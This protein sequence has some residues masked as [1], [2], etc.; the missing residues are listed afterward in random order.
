MSQDTKAFF[1]HMEFLPD[2]LLWVRDRLVQGEIEGS[3]A[4]R[5][6]LVAEEALVNVIEHAYGTE[7]G[8]IEIRLSI[9]QDKIIL[10]IRDWG[11]AYNPLENAPHVDP[12]AP[13]VERKTGGLGIYLMRKIMDDIAYE[14]QKETNLLTLTKKLDSL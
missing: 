8:N 12:H 11:P 7:P 9:L 13:L 1:S 2:M 5:L 10:A 14:R 4:K 3:L 6:E